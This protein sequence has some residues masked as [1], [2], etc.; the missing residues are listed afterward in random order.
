MKTREKFKLVNFIEDGLGKVDAKGIEFQ[1]VHRMRK[2][3]SGIVEMFA[4]QL[5][6]AF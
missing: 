5:Q 2:L 4:V 6:P 1:R 3:R